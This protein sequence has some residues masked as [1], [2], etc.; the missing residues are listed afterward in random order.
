[1]GDTHTQSAA[2]CK[3][4]RV[5]WPVVLTWPLGPAFADVAILDS[6]VRCRQR[7]SGLMAKLSSPIQSLPEAIVCL[8]SS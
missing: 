3:Q 4:E 5:E 8:P 2:V 6:S 7:P 1:M